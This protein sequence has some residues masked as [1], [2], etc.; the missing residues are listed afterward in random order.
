MRRKTYRV[1]E[2]GYCI[3]LDRRRRVLFTTDA[4]EIVKVKT[5]IVEL[6]DYLDLDVVS[7]PILVWAGLIWEDPNL[8]SPLTNYSPPRSPL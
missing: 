5:G 2:T 8:L 4:L 1:K 6:E 7:F 3:D